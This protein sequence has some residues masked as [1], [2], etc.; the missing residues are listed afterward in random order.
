MSDGPVIIKSSTKDEDS[1][2]LW[3]A[4]N[5]EPGSGLPGTPENPFP[6]PPDS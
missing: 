1:F 3:A 5:P 2:D 4:N 6:P